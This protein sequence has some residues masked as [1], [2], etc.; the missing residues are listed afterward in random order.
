MDL[1]RLLIRTPTHGDVR[2]NACLGDGLSY[3]CRSVYCNELR[4]SGAIRFV[5]INMYYNVAN[6]FK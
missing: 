6:T 1:M 2:H 5:L 3:Q 4:I